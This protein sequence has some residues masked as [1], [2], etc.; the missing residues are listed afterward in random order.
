MC[1]LAVFQRDLFFLVCPVAVPLQAF[2]AASP[3]A[4][5]QAFTESPGV[6]AAFS[7]I[8]DIK[9]TVVSYG[10]KYVRI[11]SRLVVHAHARAAQFDRGLLIPLRFAGL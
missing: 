5:S 3:L 1:C 8:Q 11:Y 10:P 4:L 7:F 2:S 6:T 9:S